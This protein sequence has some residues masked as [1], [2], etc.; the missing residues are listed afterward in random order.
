VK[1]GRR[2]SPFGFL[3]PQSVY[4]PDTALFV[5]AGPTPLARHAVSKVP[6]ITAAFRAI[7]ILTTGMGEIA[8][9]FLAHT[10]GPLVSVPQ[11]ALGLTTYTVGANSDVDKNGEATLADPAVGDSVTFSVT[12]GTT[13]IDL[14]PSGD[15][16]TCPPLPAPAQDRGPPLNR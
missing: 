11:G 14:L 16:A 7:K 4:L 1:Q 5:S 10:I 12:N 15:E 2:G 3:D 8:S 9:D 6:E 13:T